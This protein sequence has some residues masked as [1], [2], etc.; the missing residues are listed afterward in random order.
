MEP[1]SV[2]YCPHTGRV[3]VADNGA[4]CVFACQNGEVHPIIGGGGSSVQATANS[5]GSMRG[6]R[7]FERYVN[8]ALRRVTGICVMSSGEIVLAAGSELRVSH[9]FIGILMR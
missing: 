3:L 9:H 7:K 8:D 5:S 6:T 1:T 2:C 4:G